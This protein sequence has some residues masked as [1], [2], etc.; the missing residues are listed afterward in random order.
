MIGPNDNGSRQLQTVNYATEQTV[1]RERR[2]TSDLKQR[3]LAAATLTESFAIR[4]DMDAPDSSSKPNRSLRGCLLCLA[5][6]VTLAIVLPLGISHLRE[7]S[8]LAIA[9]RRA[10][11]RQKAFDEAKN[12]VRA[13]VVVMDPLLLPMLSSDADCVAN[14]EDL[15]FSMVDIQPEDAEHVARL[16]NIKRLGFY[17]SRGADVVLQHARD[18]PI[19]SLYFEMAHLSPDSLRSLSNFP[20]LT[21]VHFEHVMDP[22]EIAILKTLR[23][24]IAVEIPYPLENEPGGGNDGEPTDERE[25]D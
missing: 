14:T 15:V 3:L 17:D 6:L 8:R 21:K 22:D 18:L 25:P 11:W 5:V 10:E 4:G 13:Q 23:S 9:R 19:E 2:F 24:D 12:D 16:T 20:K 1:E 7:Q